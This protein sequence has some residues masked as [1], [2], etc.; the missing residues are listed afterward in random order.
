MG[1]QE[2]RLY[3]AIERFANVGDRGD[4]TRLVV[5][6]A[7]RSFASVFTDEDRFLHNTIHRLGD[8]YVRLSD[9][10]PERFLPKPPVWAEELTYE[11]VSE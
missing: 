9:R 3:D 10:I 2:K 1:M 5:Y 11:G 8:F 7:L 4:G 6:R